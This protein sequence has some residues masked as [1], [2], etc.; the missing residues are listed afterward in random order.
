MT[1]LEAIGSPV[2]GSY[3]DAGGAIPRRGLGVPE[4]GAAA[5]VAPR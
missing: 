3:A 5:A 1:A 4:D 2:A